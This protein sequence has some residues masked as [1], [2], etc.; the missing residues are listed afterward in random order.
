[1]LIS[2]SLFCFHIFAGALVWCLRTQPELRPVATCVLS[3]VFGTVEDVL[4]RSCIAVLLRS[5]RDGRSALALLIDGL[6]FLAGAATYE[7]LFYGLGQFYVILRYIRELSLEGLKKVILQVPRFMIRE[8][9]YLVNPSE[10]PPRITLIM[11]RRGEANQIA[12]AYRTDRFT[13]RLEAELTILN[14]MLRTKAWEQTV[15]FKGPVRRVRTVANR[16]D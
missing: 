16:D 5:W 9:R 13:S 1:M 6:C 4:I 7:L 2:L 8:V 3:N 15:D 14:M 11:K 12:Y 10:I